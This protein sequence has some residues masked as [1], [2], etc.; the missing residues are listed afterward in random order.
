MSKKT[1][2]TALVLAGGILFSVVFLLSSANSQKEKLSAIAL[3]SNEAKPK[4]A[5]APTLVAQ[6]IEKKQI[7]KIIRE[8]LIENP[9]VLEE[10]LQALQVKRQARRLAAAQTSIRKYRKQIYEDPADTVGGNPKGDVTI[11]EFFDY[12]CGFCKRVAPVVDDA[13]AKD[14]KIRFVYKE[15]PVLGPNSVLAARAA[16]ASRAQGKYIVF[17]KALMKA[18]ISYDEASIMKIATAVGIDTARLK[19]DMQA[20]GIQA[21]I[22]KTR[23]LA[24][25]LGIRGTPA[26]VVGEQLFPGALSSAQLARM[27]QM[28]RKK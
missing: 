10:A 19:K 17:H 9:E 20:P 18:K 6:S 24:R 3:A 12:R 16:L 5:P 13:L 28:A 26:F 22:A 7:E 15:F 4:A 2:F 8:Y 25:S 14:K 21:Q 27:I 1:S 23:A 11:V